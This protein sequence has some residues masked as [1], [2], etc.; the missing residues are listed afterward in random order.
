MERCGIKHQVTFCSYR[1]CYSALILS[2]QH[3]VDQCSRNMH[4][5]GL[6]MKGLNVNTQKH[7]TVTCGGGVKVSHCLSFSH[8]TE[9]SCFLSPLYS[10][11]I[12]R[13]SKFRFFFFLLVPI[14]S[15]LS[16]T[17]LPTI[18]FSRCFFFLFLFCAS[19][20]VTVQV[21]HHISDVGP[22]FDRPFWQNGL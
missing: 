20:V 13:S 10:F 5:P 7:F 2:R 22:D 18:L 3:T 9:K 21:S 12:P 17:F 6:Y 16:E 8:F 15:P 1:L 14:S 19:V 11:S 4:W